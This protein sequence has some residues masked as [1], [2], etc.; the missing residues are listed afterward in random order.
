MILFVAVLISFGKGLFFS[1]L[2]NTGGCWAG[3]VI[4][5][6]GK[7]SSMDHKKLGKT[8]F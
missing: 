7:L 3:L 6:W 5:G 8:Y 1:F 4:G 2:D